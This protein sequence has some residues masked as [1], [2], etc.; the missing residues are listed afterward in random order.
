M[1]SDNIFSMLKNVAQVWMLVI[2]MG[3][4]QTI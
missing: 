2:L 1:N 3:E 4:H